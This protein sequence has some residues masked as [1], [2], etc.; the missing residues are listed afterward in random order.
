MDTEQFNA[1]VDA[2][3]D[4]DE[5]E[6]FLG[7]TVEPEPA[8][9]SAKFDPNQPRD[10]A[11]TSTGGRFTD[12]GAQTH[13]GGVPMGPLTSAQIQALM[14]GPLP[15][16]PPAVSHPASPV[17]HT[18]NAARDKEAALARASEA[19]GIDCEKLAG[20]MSGI[21]GKFASDAKVSVKFKD[22][23]LTVNVKAHIDGDDVQFNRTFGKTESGELVVDHEEFILPPSVQGKG[24]AARALADS[25][26]LYEAYGVQHIRLY[27]NIDVG[28]YAFGK[29]GFQQEGQSFTNALRNA[30][31]GRDGADKFVKAARAAG[32]DAPRKV[33]TMAGGKELML[34]LGWNGTIDLKSAAGKEFATRLLKKSRQRAKP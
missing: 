31:H 4:L 19:L 16:S 2:V 18:P 29:L 8:T 28:G 33:A 17:S 30:V 22:G 20:G 6:P 21:V 25:L 27:A 1:L 23:S 24:I 14:D 5:Q 32:A 15:E 13:P 7:Q 26:K 10:P 11:G 34:G 9:K 3:F 12:G